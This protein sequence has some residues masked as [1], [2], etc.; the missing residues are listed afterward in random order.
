MV[1]KLSERRKICVVVRMLEPRVILNFYCV[2]SQTLVVL[3]SSSSSS[4]SSTTPHFNCHLEAFKNHPYVLPIHLCN[5]FLFSL[6]H[7]QL[8]FILSHSCFVPRFLQQ[9]QEQISVSSLNVSCSPHLLQLCL[10]WKRSWHWM[11]LLIQTRLGPMSQLLPLPRRLHF[12]NHLFYI[13]TQ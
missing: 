10:I 6:S 4:S 8:P 11:L 7:S 2:L 3:T 12:Y 1:R 5:R 9:E 13:K